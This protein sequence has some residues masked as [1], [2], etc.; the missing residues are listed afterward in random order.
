MTL[1]PAPFPPPGGP[2]LRA[3]GTSLL[4]T[5]LLL[6]VLVGAVIL[7]RQSGLIDLDETWIDS[8]IRGQGLT[9]YIVYLAVATAAICFAVPRAALSFLGGYAFGGITGSGLALGA[10]VLACIL[11]TG[12]AR[13]FARDF[14]SRRLG[15]RLQ[16]LDG[17]LTSHPFSTPM[18][19]HLIPVGSNA[20]YNL[21]GGV[22]GARLVPFV[23]G[24]AVGYVPQT[25][26]GALAGAGIHLDTG[27]ALAFLQNMFK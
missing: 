21:I 11:T 3:A 14:V 26:L 25:L 23:A 17:V 15:P 10:T 13:L 2:R 7:A 5:L 24:S 1:D 8:H 16:K 6:A 9:G 18:V 27:S 20:V 22:S 12:G 4:K 19:L